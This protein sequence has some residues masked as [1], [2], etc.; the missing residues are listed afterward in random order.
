[1]T[2][3]SSHCIHVLVVCSG[4]NSFDVPV[5]DVLCCMMAWANSIKAQQLWTL[6]LANHFFTWM[7][8]LTF[9]RLTENIMHD[10]YSCLDIDIV[11]EHCGSLSMFM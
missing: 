8:V 4:H 6:L 2:L 1:M 5:L 3:F 11:T 9:Y 10:V 7:S